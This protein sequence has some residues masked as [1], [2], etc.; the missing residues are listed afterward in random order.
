MPYDNLAGLLP[1]VS[2]RTDDPSAGARTYSDALV[3]GSIET[4]AEG[5]A[6]VATKAEPDGEEVSFD[7]AE[8]D[9]RTLEA[10]VS[11]DEEL[12]GQVPGD[13]IVLQLAVDRDE[14]ASEVES[15]LMSMG[16]LALPVESVP[17]DNYFPES[18]WVVHANTLFV[19]V[20]PSGELSLP[21]LPEKEAA[22]MLGQIDTIADLREVAAQDA[23]VRPAVA[24]GEALVAPQ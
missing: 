1:N 12:A 22:E 14:D 8:A 17:P 2:Y 19:V 4:V 5:A 15:L 23:E 24:V 6:F 20:G 7:S 18:Y 11:V 16:Q 21:A 3:T 9:W 10:T 13:S